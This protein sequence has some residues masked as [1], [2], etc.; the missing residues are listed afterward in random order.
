MRLLRL[1]LLCVFVIVTD[2]LLS[3]DMR[4]TTDAGQSVLLRK[5]GTWFYINGTPPDDANAVTYDGHVATLS[6]NG[7]WFLTNTVRPVRSTAQASPSRASTDDSYYGSHPI[8]A[9][10]A[11]DLIT[12]DGG[13]VD[14]ERVT[15][16]KIVLLY[17]S[18]HWCGPCRAFTPKLVRYYKANGGGDKF[19]IVFVSFDRSEAELGEY[20]KEAEIPWVGVSWN[21][22]GRAALQKKYCGPG[23]PCLVMLNERDEVISDSYFGK[24]YVGP[25]QVLADLDALLKTL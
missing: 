4:A 11:T 8:L 12:N 22:P 17:F 21:C 1:S 5:N 3:Q 7:K 16:K 9:G 6:K 2:Q 19:E 15:G 25:M 23:I 13:S 14:Q 10:H 24:R 18:A 20:M